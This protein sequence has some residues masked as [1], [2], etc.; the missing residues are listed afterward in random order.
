MT[1]IK[2]GGT[3]TANVFSGGDKQK[4]E[5]LQ[6]KV[7]E[8]VA[9]LEVAENKIEG[10]RIEIINLK[11]KAEAG[12]EEV[13]AEPVAEVE[14]DVPEEKEPEIKKDFAGVKGAEEDESVEKTVKSDKK[15]SKK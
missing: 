9:R 10:Q 6:N 14:T 15:K 2:E 5:N 3:T 7:A 13:E 1:S 11:D 4:I 8:L 12:K